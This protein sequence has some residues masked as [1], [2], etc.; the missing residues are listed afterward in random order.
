[1]YD[2]LVN[3]RLEGGGG[4]EENKDEIEEEEGGGE[5]RGFSFFLS[6]CFFLSIHSLNF[7]CRINS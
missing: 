5:S 6:F 3:W 7:Y 1:M 2:P 4:G